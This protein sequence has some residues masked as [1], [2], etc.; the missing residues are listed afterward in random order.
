MYI[1][2]KKEKE[3]INKLDVKAR[4]QVITVCEYIACIAVG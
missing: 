1:K 2:I 3:N 4:K